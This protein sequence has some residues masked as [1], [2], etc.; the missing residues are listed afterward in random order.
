ML[1]FLQSLFWLFVRWTPPYTSGKQWVVRLVSSDF[2][3]HPESRSQH[4]PFNLEWRNCK[5]RFRRRVDL[6]MSRTLFELRPTQIIYT[7]W[8]DSDADLN[9]SQTKNKRRKIFI[10]VIKTA[11]RV[12]YNNLRSW[13]GTW[14][15][16]RLNQSPSKVET[17]VTILSNIAWII[18][19]S[20]ETQLFLKW[21]G[22]LTVQGFF[23]QDIQ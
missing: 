12:R 8:I 17:E 7:G 4:S 20:Q 9:S 16:W 23:I 10:S 1:A 19:Q 3:I 22:S 6:F 21:H 18:K 5:A 15:V 11:Y 13:F 2:C 14:K